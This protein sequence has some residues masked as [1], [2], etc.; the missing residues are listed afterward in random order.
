MSSVYG[1]YNVNSEIDLI[2][3]EIGVF[4]CPHCRAEITSENLCK[5]CQAPMAEMLLD[6]GGKIHFCTRKGCLKHSVEF[7]DLALAIKKFYDDY[8]QYTG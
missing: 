5:T 2:S 8:D 6:M 1:S 4:S 3:D 7:E